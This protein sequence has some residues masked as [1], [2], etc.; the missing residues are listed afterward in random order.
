[1]DV[2]PRLVQMPT[3]AVALTLVN[4]RNGHCEVLTLPRS[5]VNAAVCD[6]ARRYCLPITD[7]ETTTAKAA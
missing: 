1:M 3:N 4:L 2:L 5:K 6:F 7:I